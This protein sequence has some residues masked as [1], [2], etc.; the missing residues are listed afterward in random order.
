MKFRLILF[1]LLAFC[2]TRPLDVLAFTGHT[3]DADPSPDVFHTVLFEVRTPGSEQVS[4]LFGTHHSFGKTFFDSL[5]IANEKLRSSEVMIK[6][7]M[8]IPGEQPEDIINR[9]KKTTKW[10]RYLERE[11]QEYVEAIFSNSQVDLSRLTPTELHV[12]LARVYRYRVCKAREASDPSNSLDDYI[13]TIAVENGLRLMGLE[14]PEEQLEIIDKDI[15]GMPR[16]VHKKR[17]SRLIDRMQSEDD[18]H[19]GEIEQYIA[20]DYD[21]QLDRACQNALMLTDRNARW[22]PIILEQINKNSCFIAV[23]LSHLMFE[24]GLISQLRDQGYSVTPLAV[25]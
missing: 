1:C 17:L 5:H 15:K 25:K 3:S 20:M 10:P 4:Y 18:S 12:V 13:S 21:Y 23:G 11:D 16:K 2:C 9:R 6:E 22:M 8:E 24:C 14:T 7:S 19:C